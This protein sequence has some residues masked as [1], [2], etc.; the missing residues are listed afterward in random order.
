MRI[1]ELKQ[2]DRARLLRFGAIDEN[3][4]RQLLALGL[5]PNGEMKL[6][7]RA[8][9]GCP[10]QIEVKGSTFSLREKE[11]NCLELELL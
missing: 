9:L 8:P 6:I 11:A 4:K 2:G 7:R 3:Y 10:L 1:S 5:L